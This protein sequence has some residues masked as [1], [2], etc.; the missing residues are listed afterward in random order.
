MDMTPLLPR[1]SRLRGHAK[2]L[3]QGMSD[4]E[5]CLWQHLRAGQMQGYKF[6]RQQPIGDYIADFMCLSPKLVIE[7]DGGQ[8]AQQKRADEVRSQYLRAQG[9][10]VLRFWNHDILQQTEAVLEKIRL[11]LSMLDA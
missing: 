4:A 5:R 2:A 11:T 3:R 1:H 10:V 9:F 8:H 6:R 7:A